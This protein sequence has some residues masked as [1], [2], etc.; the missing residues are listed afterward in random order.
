MSLASSYWHGDENLTASPCVRHRLR[1]PSRSRRLPEVEEEASGI[2]DH[3]VIGKQLRLLPHRRDRRPRAH[4]GPQLLHRPQ[5]TPELHRRR[6][7]QAGLHR[8]LHPAH[9]LIRTLQTSGHLSYYKDSQFAPTSSRDTLDKLSK[10]GCSRSELAHSRGGA[11]SRAVLQL[12]ASTSH[13]EAQ[14]I[15]SIASCPMTSRS[16]A[17][18]LGLAN[19][20][21]HAK[22][23]GSA[24]TL[25]RHAR[26]PR[27]VRHR[28]PLEQ[29]GEL[30]GLTRARLHSGRRPPLLHRRPDPRRDSGRLPAQ[31][32]LQRGSWA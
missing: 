21:H 15:S 6:G 14:T 11:A 5:G 26:P 10:E 16:R 27:R 31:N 32:H 8:G 24:P 28:L 20:P 17:S 4:P 3:R 9:R 22:I 12:P 18:C 29:S 2:G 30:N 23:F 7:R 25:P 13:L 1:I 19:C